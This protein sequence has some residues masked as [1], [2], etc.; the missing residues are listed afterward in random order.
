MQ[1]KKKKKDKYGNI[2]PEKCHVLDLHTRA[3]QDNIK[4]DEQKEWDETLLIV[5]L[6]VFWEEETFIG[7]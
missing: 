5:A 3:A 2:Y 6:I 4:T 7:Q 1:A